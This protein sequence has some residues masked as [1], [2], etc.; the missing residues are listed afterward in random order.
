MTCA[1]GGFQTSSD[2]SGAQGRPLIGF[3]TRDNA[4]PIGPAPISRTWMSEMSELR[5]GWPNRCLPLLIANQSGWELRNPC[6]FT[7]TWMGQDGV[8]VMIAPDSR[9]PGQFLPASHFGYG[10]LTWHLPMLFRTPPGYNLLVR[11]PANH[12]KDAVSPLE[13]IVETDW[14]SASFSMSWKF[15]RKLMPVRFEVDEPI[16]MIVPQRRA[17][18]EEFAPELRRIES[19]E[20][21][22]R[23]NELFL[24]SRDDAG[25]IQAAANIAAG[26]RLD[27]QGDYTRG[28]HRDGEA[29]TPDHQTRRHL[30]SFVQP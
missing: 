27:W 6:A 8:D 1:T 26:E 25:R 9:D 12:P 17:E 28:R 20:D 3:I 7:A 5:I 15:T 24:R 19:D 23:K 14:A 22:Q 30:R 18:L 13:G 21:L 10:I 4:P 11:G 2:K 29:G 16:C